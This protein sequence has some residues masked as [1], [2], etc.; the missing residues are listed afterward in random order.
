LNF[1]S[2]T[3]VI[4]AGNNNVGVGTASPLG[5]LHSSSASFGGTVSSNANQV[6]AENS[7]NAGITIAS[8]ATSLG[9]LFFA[10]SGDNADGYLQYDQSG[11]SMRFGTATAERMRIDS[12]GNVGIGTT[13][14]TNKLTSVYSGSSTA[15]TDYVFIGGSDTYRMIGLSEDT[16]NNAF[17]ITNKYSSGGVITFRTGAGGT[18]AERMRIDSSGSLLVGTTS[19]DSATRLRIVDGSPGTT[20]KWVTAGTGLKYL[21]EFYNDNG[22]VG[23]IS[24]SGTTTAYSTSSDYRLKENIAPMTGALAT[25]SA[26]KPCTYTWKSTGEASQGFIAHEL[27]AVV[28]DCVTGEKDAVE[29]YTDEDGVE[30]TRP[31]Y[32]GIDTSFLV[33][34]LT[35]A[36]QEL[37]AIVDAQAERI[38]ALENK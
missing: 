18:I 19:A 38:Q 6:V 24:V 22:A 27:Q 16:A 32:Q 23:R 5:K 35:S 10:D 15:V 13:T 11:R 31:K 2:N 7:G 17:A 14:P 4:D 9:N 29:T 34:T 20:S 12:S 36:I 26:L 25:V 1:D 30:Q 37:K 21:Q 3:F 8:G 33:A 28:P